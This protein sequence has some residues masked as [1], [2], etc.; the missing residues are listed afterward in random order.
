MLSIII[1]SQLTFAIMTPPPPSSQSVASK[2]FRQNGFPESL[3]QTL[4]KM[5]VRTVNELTLL[6]EVEITNEIKRHEGLGYLTSD[7]KFLLKFLEMM[8]LPT[9]QSEFGEFSIADRLQLDRLNVKTALDFRMHQAELHKFVHWP[10]EVQAAWELRQAVSSTSAEE[11]ALANAVLAA[12]MAN[13]RVL[14]LSSQYDLSRLVTSDHMR[15]TLA[16]LGNL[17]NQVQSCVAR[18]A[19]ASG[20]NVGGVRGN[21]PERE[22]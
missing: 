20:E 8:K 6:T 1:F 16:T 21:A 4:G 5:D 12:V 3:V 10:K 2:T 9:G 15:T 17:S 13:E 7:A 18:L 19:E 11:L 22:L 14:S